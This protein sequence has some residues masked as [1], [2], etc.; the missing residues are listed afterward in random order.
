MEITLNEQIEQL[1]ESE[2]YIDLKESDK[3][4][5]NLLLQNVSEV[6][7]E[8]TL[9]GDVAQ[10]TPILMPMVRRVYPA[11][12]AN[13]ILGLQALKTPTAYIYAMVNQYI[14]SGEDNSAENLTGKLKIVKTPDSVATYIYNEGDLY[15]VR[16]DADLA[17][18]TV[19]ATYTNEAAFAHIFKNYTGPYTTAAGEKLA[20]DMKEIGFEIMR[21]TVEVKSRKLKGRYTVEM[22]ED[23]KAQHGLYGDEEIMSL[24]S[25]ELQAD[26]DRECVDFVN[27]NATQLPDSTFAAKN[28]QDS[29]GRWEIERYRTEA[30]R[31]SKEA[32]QIG[33]DT[34]RGKGNIILCSPKVVTMLEQL[35]GFQAAV[36]ES[37]VNAPV[38]GGVAGTYNNSFKVIVDQ[39]ATSDYITVLYKGADRRDALGF[40]C[41]Y[42]PLAF[43]RVT[44]PE[45]GQPAIIATTRYALATI[46]GVESSTSN[47]RAKAYARTWGVDFTNTVLA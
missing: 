8:S 13:H 7:N 15:L 27:A 28:A 41:P 42:V 3:S 18:V 22:Y 2:K 5:M 16:K 17:G 44:D 4:Q 43:T 36:V 26:I 19:E 29:S 6:I 21:K 11:L 33:I 1:L 40:L 35:D 31:I 32:Q 23:F 24:M 30:I 12:I 47:D 37:N 34:K 45:S 25:Y 38:S 20:K 39:Y 46:P 14:G 9:S 10:F